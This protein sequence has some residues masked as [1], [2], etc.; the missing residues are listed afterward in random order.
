MKRTILSLAAAAAVALP[1]MATTAAAQ[2]EYVRIC[3]DV[4]NNEAGWYYVPGTEVCFNAATGELV[5]QGL[6][7]PNFGITIVDRVETLEERVGFALSGAAIGIALPSPI[8]PEGHTFAITGNWGQVGGAHAF[9]LATAVQVT[10]HFLITGGAGFGVGTG[11]VGTRAG[12][13][14]SFGGR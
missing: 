12:W 9:G 10:P 3:N 13:N 5:N 8:M 1:L 7:T 14:L 11:V 4:N 6:N 2:V